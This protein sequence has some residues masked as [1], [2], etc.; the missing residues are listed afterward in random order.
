MADA[1]YCNPRG[2]AAVKQQRAEIIVRLNPLSLPLQDPSGRPWSAL[3]ALKKLR[4]AREVG[5]WPVGVVA[6]GAR[7]AGRVCG[8]RK[9]EQ[10]IEK[11]QRRLTRR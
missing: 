2:I 6:E 8:I 11:T 7:I 9:S 3:P 1:A 5:D 10:A 4:R